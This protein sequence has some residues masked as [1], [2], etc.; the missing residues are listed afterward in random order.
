MKA[1]EEFTQYF[2]TNTLDGSLFL[3]IVNRKL[4][5]LIFHRYDDQSGFI[6]NICCRRREKYVITYKLQ[7]YKYKH[8]MARDMIFKTKGNYI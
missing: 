4:F 6:C 5:W 3:I 8:T 2:F 1:Y 7:K